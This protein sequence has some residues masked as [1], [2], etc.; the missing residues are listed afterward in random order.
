MIKGVVPQPCTQYSVGSVF[1]WFGGS[2]YGNRNLVLSTQGDRGR[3]LGRGLVLSDDVV[4]EII[5]GGV[6]PLV[7]PLV[8]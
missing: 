2:S 1:C 3:G 7:V 8:Q 6:V 5:G 4:E